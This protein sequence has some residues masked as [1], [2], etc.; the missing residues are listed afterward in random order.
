MENRLSISKQVLSN[1]GI[2]C[3]AIDDEEISSL[4]SILERIFYSE[5]G[6]VPVRSNLSW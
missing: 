3:V 4:R 2:I 6:I 5:L 1:Q